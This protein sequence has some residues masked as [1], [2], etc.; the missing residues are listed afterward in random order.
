ME[1][2]TC[3]ARKKEDKHQRIRKDDKKNT[4]VVHVV[5]QRRVELMQG[6]ECELQER[7]W[8]FPGCCLV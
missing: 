5:K 3:L 6:A 7:R 4:Q 8:L 2:A 1:N